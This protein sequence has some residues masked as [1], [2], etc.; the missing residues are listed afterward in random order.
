MS[1]LKALYLL[2]ES[3][4]DQIYGPDER[5]DIEELVELVAPLQTA[6]SIAEN[7]TVLA[8]VEVILSGW[9]MIPMDEAFLAAAPRLK[10]FFYGAGSIKHIVSDAFWAR[11]IPITSAYAANA[12]PV[13]EFTLAQILLSLK[14]TWYYIFAIREQKQYVPRLPMPGAYGS[15]VGLI[16]LGMIGSGVARKLQQFDLHVIAYDPFVSDE[17]AADLGVELCSLD[18]IFA[19]ADVVSLHAPWLDETVG[20]I[21][22]DH[23]ARMKPDATFINTARGAI[24]REDEMIRVLQ[25]RPDLWAILDVTYPEPPPPGSPLYTLPNVVLT[26]HIAGSLDNECRRMGRQIVDELRRFLHDE[27]L[28]WAIGWEQAAIMA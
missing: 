14:R 9:G 7:P 22:G 21:R 10:A 6:R 12:V 18:E 28:Q 25:D 16:S 4:F 20:M 23:F 15:T 17:R 3:A 26:P 8:E 11:G 1:K 24:V 27:P 13:I 5:R 19:R 2:N